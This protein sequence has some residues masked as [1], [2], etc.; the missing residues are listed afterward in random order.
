MLLRDS[1]FDPRKDGPLKVIADNSSIMYLELRA[2]EMIQQ[3]Q[4]DADDVR[5]DAEQRS[6]ECDIKLSQAISLIVLARA[7]RLEKKT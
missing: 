2:I 5:L 1:A 7:R 3:A 6:K 4:L